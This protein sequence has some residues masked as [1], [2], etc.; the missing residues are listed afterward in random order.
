MNIYLHVEVSSRELDSKLLLAF[1]AASKGH[2]V[3]VSDL[4]EII[5]GLKMGLLKPGIFHTK[6]I[7]PGQTKINRH[8]NLID[9]GNL[10]TSIDEESGITT[11]GYDDMVKLRYSEKT[12][13]QASAVFGWGPEDTAVLKKK[14]P[15]YADKIHKTGSPRI[16]LWGS[17]LDGYWEKPKN[18]PDRPYLLISSNMVCTNMKPFHE[19]LNF[20]K[21]AGYLE[22]DPKMQEMLFKEMSEDYTRLNYF[23]NAIKHMSTNNNGY[24]IV[25]RPHPSENIET[26]RAFL[27]GIPNVHVIREG[28]ITPWIKNAFA[29][30]HN[31]CTS[32]FEAEFMGK[33][34]ITFIP[35]HQVYGHHLANMMG[36]CV[37][38]NEEILEKANLLFDESK[39]TKSN[40]G[41][42][43]NDIMKNKIYFDKE[44]LAAEKMIKI[45]ES[46]DNKNLS[47]SVNWVKFEYFL[48]LKKYRKMFTNH[49]KKLVLSRYKSPNINYKFPDLNEQEVYNKFK[50]LKKIF[51]FKKKIN[52][53]LL[54]NKTI[55]I[56]AD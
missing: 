55:L 22:R 17:F 51:K 10:I 35:F 7:T 53:K 41:N 13:G 54:S 4:S 31:S 19:I 23:I 11:S 12:I 42:Q 36:S 44:E 15:Y 49:I 18:T 24:D 25:L 16:D 39:S 29:V 46:L 43:L 20:Y 14:F 50:R 5:N 34:V 37:K 47:K 52:F 1:L 45:W 40:R 2:E 9:N 26:W 56:K 6:S 3:I 48:K 27:D 38:N 21:R 30:M 33:P 8:Q 28:S 32:A